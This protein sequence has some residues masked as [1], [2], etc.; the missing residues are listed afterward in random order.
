MH[1]ALK[2]PLTGYE[3]LQNT[4]IPLPTLAIDFP[5]ISDALFFVRTKTGSYILKQLMNEHGRD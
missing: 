3:M 4:Q 1:V 5:R 2:A